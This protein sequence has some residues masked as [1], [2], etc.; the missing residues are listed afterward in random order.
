MGKFSGLLMV[1]DLDRTLFGESETQFIL[2]QN[3]KAIEYFM[4]NGGYF[5]FATGRGF[6]AAGKL[7][8]DVP[9]NAPAILFNG[10]MIYDFEKNEKVFS[11]DIS[12]ENIKV[13]LGKMC[14]KFSNVPKVVFYQ[15]KMFSVNDDIAT[16][17]MKNR[18]NMEGERRDFREVPLPWI[19][20][21]L[22]SDERTVNEMMDYAKTLDLTGLQCVCSTPV[23]M[24]TM[25][26]GVS[27]A[28]GLK[29]LAEILGID[30]KNTI[31]IGDYYNDEAML[32]AA[33]H[34]FV[35]E[36][37]AEDLKPLAEKVVCHHRDGAIADVIEYL[38]N[39]F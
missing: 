3:N 9:K 15:N 38:D 12:T 17:N 30:M 25:K 34:T 22:A 36:N 37:A 31:A 16:D 4:A 20:I 19:K 35:P 28:T 32:R 26:A 24:E 7:T 10:Q 29:K 13:F 8:K 2:P 27:K 39:H 5:T 33:G 14:E 6:V 18:I 23:L 21:L 11:D 1:S